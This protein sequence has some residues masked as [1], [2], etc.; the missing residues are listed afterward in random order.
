MSVNL[1]AMARLLICFI[2]P[3]TTQKCRDTRKHPLNDFIGE[4]FFNLLIY[5]FLI[6]GIWTWQVPFGMKHCRCRNDIFLFPSV[7]SGSALKLSEPQSL[8]VFL[9]VSIKKKTS[10]KFF[11]LHFNLTS[12]FCFFKFLL[13]IS[14]IFSSWGATL[15]Y[16]HAKCICTLQRLGSCT[17]LISSHISHLSVQTQCS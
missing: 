12:L 9:G 2:S 16:S 5:I 3:H 1:V 10:H 4:R 7:F 13:Q 6:D 15:K 17:A 11:F 8:T 14:Y